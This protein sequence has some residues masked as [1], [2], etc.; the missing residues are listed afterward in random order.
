MWCYNMCEKFQSNFRKKKHNFFWSEL[1]HYL[2]W[3]AQYKYEDQVWVW[4]TSIERQQQMFFCVL[5]ENGLFGSILF[6]FANIQV[7]YL[8]TSALSPSVRSR[9]NF[10]KYWMTAELA[11]GKK[12][13]ENWAER[14][15]KTSC[16]LTFMK[17]AYTG[18]DAFHDMFF[19]L[20]F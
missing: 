1:A 8:K 20:L 19:G 11:K 4:L 3:P 7:S 15:L 12:P 10:E 18:C 9:W 17:Q 5:V 6:I 13:Y 14:A 16:K 2:T